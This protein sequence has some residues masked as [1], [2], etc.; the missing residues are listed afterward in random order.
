MPGAVARRTISMACGPRDLIVEVVMCARCGTDKTI[1]LRGHPNV[2]PYAPVVL[3]HELVARVVEVGGDVCNIRKGIGYRRGHELSESYLDFRPGERL[4]F[5]SRIARYDDH[6]LMLLPNPIANLSFQIDG[7]YAQY[8][9]VPEA[10]I[11]SESALRVPDNATDEE[12]CLVEPS[13]CAL[14]SI[15]ATPHPIGVDE[16]GRHKY[17]AGILP[18]GSVCV[19]GSG[20]VSMIYAALAVL[21]GAGRVVMMVRSERK[22]A[23][24]SRLLG[25]AVE[26]YLAPRTCEDAS[27]ETLEA[28]ESVV[29]DLVDLTG[30]RLFDDVIAACASPAAQ[31][32]M[33]RLYNPEGYAVGA[34]FGGARELVDRADIDANHYRAAKTI[35]TSGCSTSCMKTILKWL[36]SDR[37]DLNGFTSRRRFTLED[38]PHEFLTTDADGLKPVLYM[39]QR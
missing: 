20:T 10:M 24:V 33:L 23:L 35:G 18:G 26:V 22:A 6:G 2:D 25:S 15:F 11:A 17:R 19:I 1:Y 30:G 32:L 9:K 7:G 3:G 36:E 12:A 4:V 37:L 21:E 14:E 38:D 34:C 39:G 5:Q 27:G 28:E 16:E 29:R 8:M 31:R 13:A